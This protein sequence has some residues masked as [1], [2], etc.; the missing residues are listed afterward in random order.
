MNK[1]PGRRPDFP[2]L[3]LKTAEDLTI[4]LLERRVVGRGRAPQLIA[5]FGKECLRMLENEEGSGL[6]LMSL[7]ARIT[8]RLAE[9]G[10]V[11]APEGI[12]L[13]LESNLDALRA[14]ARGLPPERA[15]VILGSAVSVALKML[16]TKILSAADIA[17]SLRLTAQAALEVFAARGGAEKP[18]GEKP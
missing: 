13:S 4:R 14:A 1:P 12:V 15:G 11:S 5:Y 16:E 17:E 8:G 10:S 18:E 2:A 6:P 3:A 9:R 7:A